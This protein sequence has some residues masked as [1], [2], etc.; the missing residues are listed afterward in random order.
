MEHT[1]HMTVEHGWRTMSV[2]FTAL[3]HTQQFK[4]ESKTSAHKHLHLSKH[5]Q[6]LIHCCV[7]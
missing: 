4:L 3:T 1:D 5:S 2:V 6:H 7:Y